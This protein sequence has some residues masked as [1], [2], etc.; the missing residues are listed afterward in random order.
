[1]SMVYNYPHISNM[2]SEI[3]DPLL[4]ATTMATGGLAA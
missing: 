4:L 1:M 3:S 2:P